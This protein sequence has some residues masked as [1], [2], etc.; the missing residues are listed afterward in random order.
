MTFTSAHF[1]WVKAHPMAGPSFFRGWEGTIPLSSPGDGNHACLVIQSCPTLCNPMD[2]SPPG[3]SV[4]GILQA[5]ILEWVAMSTSSR[6]FPTQGSNSGILHCRW[7]LY[8]LSHQGSLKY[9]EQHECLPQQKCQAWPSFI[10]SLL[11]TL[12]VCYAA[13]TKCHRLGG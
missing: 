2:C 1:V 3:F 4:H 9:L 11:V 5:R 10:T 12:L 7:I 13:L 6:G 8:H